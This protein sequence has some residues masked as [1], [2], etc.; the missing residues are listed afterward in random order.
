MSPPLRQSRDEAGDSSPKPGLTLTPGRAG[1]TTTY[2][3][4]A[5]A[6][7]DF[8]DIRLPSRLATLR[9]FDQLN[10]EFGGF[11]QVEGR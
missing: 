4:P 6:C 3:S 10:F 8:W 9:C 7:G 11:H 1:L 5:G 2:P